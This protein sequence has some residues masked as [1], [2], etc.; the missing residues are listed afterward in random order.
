ML[1]LHINGNVLLCKNSINLFE[2]LKFSGHIM[3][4][5]CFHSNLQVSG[6]CRVCLVEVQNMEKPIASCVTDLE[7]NLSVWTNTPFTK[8]AKENIFEILL[9]NHPLDCPI[10]DQAGE[11]DLQDQSKKFGGLFTRFFFQKRSVTDKNCGFFIKTIMTR[12]IH[13][14]RCVRFS[15]ISGNETIGLLNRGQLSEI[16]TYSF[17]EFNF[18]LLG[19]IIDLC[20]VGALTAR[21][22]SFQ[23]R[24]WELKMTE[25]LDLTDGICSNIYV[26]YKDTEIYK[27]SP[28]P[29]NFLNGNIITDKCRFSYD[30]LTTNRLKKIYKYDYKEFSYK[31]LSWFSFLNDINL[32]NKNKL[33][34]ILITEDRKSVV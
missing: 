27:I 25:C 21:T 9:R 32:F 5:F 2:A 30:A 20:P 8:K 19:N 7:P 22:Y 15:E 34:N 28:K 4:R 18:E 26:N 12:C 33:V 6:S 14:T 11:C 24:P 10:C 13:C 29:N 23:S 16:G 1:K 17:K 3:S 31:S